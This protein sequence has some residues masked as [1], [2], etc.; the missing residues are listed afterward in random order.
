MDFIH[1]YQSVYDSIGYNA[2]EYKPF[3]KSLFPNEKQVTIK[4]VSCQKQTGG[5]A[6]GLFCLANAT[7]LCFGYDPNNY[8]WDQ[9]DMVNC[10]NKFLENLK[11]ELFTF[12]EKNIQERKYLNLT[13]FPW[14]KI[15]KYSF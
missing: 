6:C 8:I 4:K 11:V 13:C 3:F 9:K 10:Y 15:I 14:I 12:S 1:K 7:A 2:K 5:S